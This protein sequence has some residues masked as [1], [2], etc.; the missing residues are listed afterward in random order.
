MCRLF[1]YIENQRMGNNELDK[2]T[3]VMYCLFN[4]SSAYTVQKKKKKRM[5]SIA[6]IQ[7]D[8]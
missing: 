6:A 2:K 8:L 4:T 5:V 1:F 3:M 7:T